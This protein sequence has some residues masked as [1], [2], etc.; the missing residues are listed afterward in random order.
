MRPTRILQYVCPD[1]WKDEKVVPKKYF[2]AEDGRIRGV[3]LVGLEIDL[4]SHRDFGDLRGP[5]QAPG[6]FA[7]A[8]D[9]CRVHFPEH[10]RGRNFGKLED[11]RRPNGHVWLHKWPIT[12]IEELQTPWVSAYGHCPG[13]GEGMRYGIIMPFT[14]RVDDVFRI[15]GRIEAYRAERILA[16]LET[17]APPGVRT[18]L[19]WLCAP[20]RRARHYDESIRAQ[21]ITC[22]NPSVLWCCSPAEADALWRAITPVLVED[23][24]EE[25]ARDKRPAKDHAE[26]RYHPRRILA[27]HLS[28]VSPRDDDAMTLAALAFLSLGE[29]GVIS[30]QYCLGR[31]GSKIADCDP[32]EIEKLEAGLNLTDEDRR[33]LA[34]LRRE[35]GL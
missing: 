5:R 12:P 9:G 31:P 30:F 35:L 6:V 8:E 13:A 26:F 16:R 23:L 17:D 24:R 15:I 34:R 33:T 20:G 18:F 19:E 14:T 3:R 10:D 2:L 1:D 28:A 27:E 4:D 22:V 32:D 7:D 21:W 25:M 11:D 29:S